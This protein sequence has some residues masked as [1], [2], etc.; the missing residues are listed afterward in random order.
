[1]EGGWGSGALGR[2]LQ[3]GSPFDTILSFPQAL[4][5]G[6]QMFPTLSFHFVSFPFL[7]IGY[8]LSLTLNPNLKV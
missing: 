3:L 1:M 2:G 5:S 4:F 8:I 7:P 6:P